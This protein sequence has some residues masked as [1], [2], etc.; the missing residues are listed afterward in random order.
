MAESEDYDKSATPLA[1]KTSHENGG[2]DEI[3]V[4]ELSG[5]L[6]D[7]Q[8]SSWALVSY[9]PTT[10][11]PA[12]HKTSHQALGSDEIFVAGLAGELTA[13][14]KSSWAKVSGKPTAFAPEAHKTSHQLAG[15]DALS[16]AGLSGLLATAQTPLAHKTSHENGGSDEISVASLSG[17]LA[18]GQA[19][20]GHKTSHQVEGSD[21]IDPTGWFQKARV[22]RAAAQTVPDVTWTKIEID[23]AYYDPGSIF[24]LTNNRIKPT[25][26]GYYQINGQIWIILGGVPVEITIAV[27]SSGVQACLG[28]RF[29]ATG[30]V[31]G[32][33]VNDILYQ[34][35]TTDYIELWAYL[36]SGSSK[37]IFNIPLANYLSL[38]G[39]F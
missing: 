23:T 34:N 29:Y 6:A 17:L 7:A 31:G 3:S 33:T 20:L 1:H 5:Q 24:D 4:D 26:P 21:I 35:G 8:P 28:N 15:S 10:F 9:K 32:A 16:V 36:T 22:Y 27:Y 14:Q 19:P 25:K 12:A 39:P 38:I 18:D 2:S 11:T 37:D 13:E 30:S